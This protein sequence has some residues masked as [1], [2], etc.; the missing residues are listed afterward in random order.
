MTARVAPGHPVAKKH[1]FFSLG[2]TRDA[3]RPTSVA[4]KLPGLDVLRETIAEH[5]RLQG[6][7]PQDD[8]RFRVSEE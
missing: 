6:A 5:I 4:M 7:E 3:R 2:P 8:D 1:W